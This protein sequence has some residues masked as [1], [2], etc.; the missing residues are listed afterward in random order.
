MVDRS[1]LNTEIRAMDKSNLEKEVEPIDSTQKFADQSGLYREEFQT[2]LANLNFNNLKELSIK[3]SKNELL[4]VISSPIRLIDFE[5]LE[6]ELLNQGIL[7]KVS[8][9]LSQI[10]IREVSHLKWT[11]RHFF[12]TDNQLELYIDVPLYLLK[13]ADQNLETSL[14]ENISIDFLSTQDLSYL[15]QFAAYL[16]GEY[17]ETNNSYE[18]GLNLILKTIRS[19]NSANESINKDSNGLTKV[20]LPVS[21]KSLIKTL[22]RDNQK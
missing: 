1:L 6:A 19:G 2:R 18:K 22:I 13:K 14:A 3:R 17:E 9:T 5:M 7:P 20:I 10:L 8:E 12:K 4:K 21:Q 15:E 11:T 16:L